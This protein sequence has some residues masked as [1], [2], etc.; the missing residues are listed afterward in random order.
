MEKGAVG[1]NLGRNVWQNPN[2]VGMAKALQQIVHKSISVA[3][4]EKIYKEG[5]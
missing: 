2:P 1:L 5:K 3:E 4:A